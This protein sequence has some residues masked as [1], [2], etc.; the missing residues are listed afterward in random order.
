MRRQT[1]DIIPMMNKCRLSVVDGGPTLIQQ[2]SDVLWLTG[3][4]HVKSRNISL[5]VRWTTRRDDDLWAGVLDQ[6][7]WAFKWC[8]SSTSSDSMYMIRR[9]IRQPL[10]FIIFSR[11]L[12]LNS[13]VACFTNTHPLPA[14]GSEAHVY[15]IDKE[16]LLR[17]VISNLHQLAE[18]LNPYIG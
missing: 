7:Q 15:I 11:F 4:P 6:S 8:D 17:V 13:K 10:C 16:L 14:L 9:S 18:I 1:R 2:C 12:A 3:M 5:H